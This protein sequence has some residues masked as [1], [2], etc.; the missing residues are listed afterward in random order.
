M[1]FHGFS[2]A[3]N[4]LVCPLTWLV[5]QSLDGTGTDR[6]TVL[7]DHRPLAFNQNVVARSGHVLSKIEP[8]T[9]SKSAKIALNI[10]TSNRAD[11]TNKVVVMKKKDIVDMFSREKKKFEPL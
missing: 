2:D 3:L 8:R 1:G 9:L 10:V 11:F 5:E 4:P 7:L 6:V